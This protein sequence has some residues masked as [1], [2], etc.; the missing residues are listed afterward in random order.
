MADTLITLSGMCDF[1]Q[2]WMQ[3]CEPLFAWVSMS[4]A[5]FILLRRLV[6][7]SC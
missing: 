5:K 7:F 3:Q 2:E 6:W 1:W 4:A